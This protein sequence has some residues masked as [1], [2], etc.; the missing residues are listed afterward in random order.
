MN[1][2]QLQTLLKNKQVKAFLR[3]PLGM[4]AGAVIVVTLLV[5]GYFSD[6]TS[7]SNTAPTTVYP[8]KNYSLQGLVTHVADG[9]TINL[10]VNGQRERIRLANI[11]APES[12]GRVDRPGQPYAKESKQAL[13]AMVADKTMSLHCYEQ[14]HYGR[15][16]C[17]ILLANGKT[18]NQELV[19]N[20]WAWAYT[21][22]NGRYL[23]DKSLI[24]VQAKAKKAGLGLWQDKNPI[25]P[26]AWRVDCW[27]KKKCN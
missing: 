11:D 19:V 21:G 3:T 14:D 10:Q 7:T 26:W 22:S 5:T 15:H 4:I 6:D 20:G 8:A 27:Q 24:E 18:A 12:G 23:R 2:K 13:A 1:N 17:D 25:A 9:D 16:V